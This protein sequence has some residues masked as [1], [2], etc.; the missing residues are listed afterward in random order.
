VTIPP[1]TVTCA[2]R[3]APRRWWLIISI[4]LVRATVGAIVEFDGL[5]F[6]PRSGTR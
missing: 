5:D 6:A 4:R 3:A 1:S 2:E